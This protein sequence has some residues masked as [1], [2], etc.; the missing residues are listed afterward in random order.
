M[1]VRVKLYLCAF[2]GLAGLAVVGVF[3]LLGMKYVGGQISQLTEKSTPVQ[4]KTI[5]FQR[6]L[7]EHT[8]N[9]LRI[10]VA[11]SRED[12]DKA[13]KEADASLAE[14]RK[15][16]AD[17]DALKGGAS[18]GGSAVSQV[19]AL[20]EAT[21]Q[22]AGT[23]ADRIASAAASAEALK[24]MNA[25]MEA[26]S[27][28]LAALDDSIRKVQV[29]SSG[30]LK[31]TNESVT[32]ISAQQRS[33]QELKDYLKDMKLSLMELTAADLKNEVPV[34]RNHFNSAYRFLMGNEL[35]KGGQAGAGKVLADSL[36]EIGKAV[37]DKGGLV[38]AKTALIA[39]PD[40]EGSKKFALGMKQVVQKVTNLMSDMESR[41][42]AATAEASEENQKF[43]ASLKGSD[44]AGG[45]LM[46][47][48]QL[49]ALGST[50]E[51]R[52]GLLFGART[53]KRLSD[54][55]ADLQ[56]KLSAADAIVK[57]E[58]AALAAAG[59]TAEGKSLKEAGAS[60][61][62][63]RATLFAKGGVVEKIQGELT[64][65]EK[66]VEL[67]RKIRETVEKQR[68]EGRKGV[69]LAQGE[70]EK[71]VLAVNRIVRSSTVLVAVLG[72]VCMVVGTLFG[73]MLV[74]SITSQIHQ[75]S[76][77]AEAFGDGD[78][79]AR[80][81]DSSKDEFGV[82]A[83]QFNHTAEQLGD[84]TGRIADAIATLSAGSEELAAAA[85]EMSASATEVAAMTQTN[86]G[87]AAKT[88]K[89]MT[90][91]LDV[92]EKSDG[93]MRELTGA[94]AEMA[95]ASEEA[96]RIVK[97]IN[98]IAT[99]TNLLA[100]NAAVEAAHAGAAGE[101]FAVVAE[102]VK[103]LAS[104]AAEAAKSTEG[105]IH[106]IV[107]KVRHGTDLVSSTSEAFQKVVTISGQ[108]GE[109]VT[110]IASGSKE[111]ATGINEISTGVSEITRVSQSNSESAQELASAISIFK[112]S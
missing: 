34:A 3:S 59:Y 8:S 96:E 67:S 95:S 23:T 33:I 102:E 12:F 1:K 69:T 94:M 58:S 76:A 24:T 46:L 7:Q 106:E 10:Q 50:L 84:M 85:E 98:L 91:S 111:Q 55:S 11:E 104:R 28:K 2:V 70:Q 54:L 49:M 92:I 57:K 42:E 30:S 78:L 77:L 60:L 22:I 99:Q 36:P 103:N 74:R 105:L 62:E 68:E 17:L 64:I 71:T 65:I 5:D 100:L 83:S 31:V 18:G 44:S 110:G 48:S 79:T 73:T 14:V 40:E 4:L 66:A 109:L 88:D 101:G 21:K 61:A 29:K 19:E 38:E 56:A 41:I 32:R 6:A 52:V 63:I 39:T 13:G 107:Q 35:V 53:A 80:M 75:L 25:R 43:G 9:L 82:L 20:A 15:V 87:N 81:D 27:R 86:A 112:T 89:L 90:E 47:N 16:A 51:G 72:T 26:M 93:F 45:I 97:T 108:V 37:L